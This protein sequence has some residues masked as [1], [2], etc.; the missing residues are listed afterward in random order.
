MY[1]LTKCKSECVSLITIILLILISCIP[2]TEAQKS[3]AL[4]LTTPEGVRLLKNKSFDDSEQARKE[5][6]ELY[7]DC[8]SQMCLM[9]WT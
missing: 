8:D 6:L 5:I 1:C 3:N 7:K 9:V 2:V 4:K